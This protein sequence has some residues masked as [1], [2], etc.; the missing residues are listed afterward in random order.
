MYLATG[1]RRV[2]AGGGVDSEDITVYEVPLGEVEVFL[3][4]QAARGRAVDLKVYS[5][6]HFARRVT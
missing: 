1:L 6:L 4:E 3:R 5:A 2:G